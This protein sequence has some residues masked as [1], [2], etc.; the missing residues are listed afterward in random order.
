VISSK[1]Q[2]VALG[3][4]LAIREGRDGWSP[5]SSFGRKTGI[6]HCIEIWKIGIY[7]AIQS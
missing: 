1:A 5:L 2:P 4:Q 3:V 6:F 7:E